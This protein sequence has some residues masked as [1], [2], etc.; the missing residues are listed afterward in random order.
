MESVTVA[1]G[2]LLCLP[3]ASNAFICKVVV[4]SDVPKCDETYSLTGTLL[5]LPVSSLS[6]S[7]RLAYIIRLSKKTAFSFVDPFLILLYFFETKFALSPRLGCNGTVLT[8]CNLHFLASSDSPASASRVAGITGTCHHA[9]LIF[10]IFSRDGFHH[11]GQD[12]LD[13]LTS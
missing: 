6:T 2:E 5:S 1:K 4:P 7:R 8:H 12:G 11:V 9:P 13:L 3:L 10:C